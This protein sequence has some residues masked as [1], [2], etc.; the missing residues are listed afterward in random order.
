MNRCPLWTVVRWNLIII[1]YRH[2]R[3]D[4]L[5]K[6]AESNFE[7]NLFHHLRQLAL[8]NVDTC[9]LPPENTCCCFSLKIRK[10]E[11]EYSLQLRQSAR[12]WSGGGEDSSTFERIDGSDNEDEK[13]K[14]GT[15]SEEETSQSEG[16][17]HQKCERFC[18]FSWH[19]FFY[20][21]YSLDGQGT[22]H[23]EALVSALENM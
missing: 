2:I 19:V 11:E 16:Y 1:R 21:S 6:P 14:E 5:R 9:L 10:K 7:N 13:E 4:G 3:S 22:C 17:C 15:E 23:E 12:G 8:L 20:F 18:Y